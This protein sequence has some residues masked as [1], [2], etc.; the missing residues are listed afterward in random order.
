MRL[1]ALA[2]YADVAAQTGSVAAADTLYELLEPWANQ[3]VY[4]GV[5]GYGHARMYLG[6][7]DHTLGRDELAVEHLE[8]ACRFHEEHGLLLWAAQSHLWLARRNRRSLA[9]EEH[10]ETPSADEHVHPVG[11]QF[12]GVN[13][14]RMD[15]RAAWCAGRPWST[16]RSSAHL[17]RRH[18]VDRAVAEHRHDPARG[19]PVAPLEG[20]PGLAQQTRVVG[21]RRR[22]RTSYLLEPLEPLLTKFADGGLPLRRLTPDALLL[23]SSRACSSIAATAATVASPLSSQPSGQ[24]PRRLRHPPSPSASCQAGPSLRVF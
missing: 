1:T 22:L 21:N 18:R 4:T 14:R 23:P 20:D 5:L 10:R 6:Q 24:R 15:R 16:T 17:R 12:A 9:P 13:Q 7:L 19:L 11:P 8:F 2:L 3:V